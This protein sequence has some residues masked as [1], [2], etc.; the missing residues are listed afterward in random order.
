MVVGFASSSCR[1][2]P[3]GYLVQSRSA[4]AGQLTA[5]ATLARC[6]GGWCETLAIGASADGAQ[7][8]ATLQPSVERCTE[9]AWS[10]NGARVGF[11]INGTQLRL[12][13]AA[14]HAPAGQIDLVPR[15]AD[16]STRIARGLTFSDNGAAITFDDCPRDR[17]GCRPG[18]VALR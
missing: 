12:Y 4:P 7:A 2:G 10:R 9:I 16:P 8:V 15:D 1:R 5:A 3:E 17:S 11:L 13:D 18:I 14:S 6:D